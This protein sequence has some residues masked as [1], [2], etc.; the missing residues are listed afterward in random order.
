MCRGMS[1]P[2]YRMDEHF[3]LS[4]FAFNCNDVFLNKKEKKKGKKG[5]IFNCK[6]QNLYVV[7]FQEL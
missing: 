3:L 4:N 7:E 6:L 2:C 5:L 1:F